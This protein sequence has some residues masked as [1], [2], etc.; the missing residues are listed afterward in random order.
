MSK[1]SLTTRKILSILVK[2][3]MEFHGYSITERCLSD[4]VEV[5]TTTNSSSV[6]CEMDGMVRVEENY[7]TNLLTRHITLKDGTE[8]PPSQYFEYDLPQTLHSIKKAIKECDGDINQVAIVSDLPLSRIQEG[9]LTKRYPP[10]ENLLEAIYGEIKPI[11][12]LT[13]GISL[14]E[15]DQ[16]TIFTELAEMEARKNAPSP[17]PM[18]IDIAAG[19]LEFVRKDPI[20]EIQESDDGSL[21]FFHLSGKATKFVP[22]K[23]DTSWKEELK[24]SRSEFHESISEIESNI[25]EQLKHFER[26][27]KEIPSVDEVVNSL[28]EHFDYF[29]AINESKEAMMEFVKLQLDSFEVPEKVIEV[30]HHTTE[31]VEQKI[32]VE[33]KIEE[34]VSEQISKIKD[35]SNYP[36]L[37]EDASTQTSPHIKDIEIRNNELIVKFMDGNERSLGKI[38]HESLEF[39]G[40]GVQGET[41]RAGLS[42]YQIAKKYGYVGTEEEWL[43][44]IGGSGGAYT[45]ETPSIISVGGIPAGTTFNNTTFDEFVSMLLYPELN[46]TLVNPSHSFTITNAGLQEIGSVVSVAG[47]TTFSRGSIDP[48][49]TS[50]SPFRSGLPD[51]FVFVDPIPDAYENVTTNLTSGF[52]FGDFTVPNGTLTFQSFVEY[53]EGV[54]PKSSSGNDFSTPLPAGSTTPSSRTI[55]GVYPVFATVTTIDDV[56]KLPLT[57]FNALIQVEMVNERGDGIKQRIDFPLDDWNPINV[58]EQ[59]NEL[60]SAWEAIDINSFTISTTTHVIQGNEI[61]YRRYTHNGSVVGNRRMRWRT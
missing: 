56:S 42:A 47:T 46:P 45:N 5:L 34:L 24:K 18:S 52:Q 35:R 4:I 50:E 29:S 27:Q 17:E 54:Q 55:T 11:L 15:S 21:S 19:L 6:V 31:L 22:E 30:H 41:G 49:Y 40:Y 38:R 26:S 32:D 12:K 33:S 14:L 3:S 13:K 2:D 25:E 28:I 58:I 37:S 16:G 59:W 10:Y 1:T 57:A 43:N 44:S 60:S 39:G 61:Q 51:S 36:I 53:S 23:D 7:S 9:T 20:V 48:Q 8:F